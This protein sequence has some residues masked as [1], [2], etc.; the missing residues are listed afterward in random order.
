MAD[1]SYPTDGIGN[2]IKKGA[3]LQV[4][5][6]SASLIFRVVDVE[7]AGS[8]LA[9][10]LGQQPMAL[11]GTILIQASVPVPFT[12]GARMENMLVLREPETTPAGMTQ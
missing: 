5:L 10:E 4:T 6:P 2:P 12:E 1:R 3:L 8:I 9:K 11:T 7:P